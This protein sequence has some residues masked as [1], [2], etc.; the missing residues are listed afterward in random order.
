MLPSVSLYFEYDIVSLNVLQVLVAAFA[1]S[2]YASTVTR[3]AH[4]PFN[5]LLGETY[6]CVR[7]DRG[8]RFISEQVGPDV[9][10]AYVNVPVSCE[11]VQHIVA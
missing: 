7:E 11:F 4:K 10:V 8:W 2:S 6:E 1:I 5:P 9:V 3:C